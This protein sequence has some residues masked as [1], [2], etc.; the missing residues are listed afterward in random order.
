[1]PMRID[2]LPKGARTGHP[3]E[4]LPCMVAW[5]TARQA[6]IQITNSARM[7]CAMTS[8]AP[9][10]SVRIRYSVLGVWY[11]ARTPESVSRARIT[12]TVVGDICTV[13]QN[14]KYGRLETTIA[15]SVAHLT[16][17]NLRATKKK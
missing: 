8:A 6:R 5:V 15:A 7:G 1:M 10:I 4:A 16:G 2:K 9:E 3:K 14:P 13:V 17:S 11:S 12:P